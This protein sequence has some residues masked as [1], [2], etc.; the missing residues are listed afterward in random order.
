[1]FA[2][3][4]RLKEALS[5][6]V[7]AAALAACWSGKAS[8]SST[9]PTTG[10]LTVAIA[11]LTGTTGRVTV[12]GPGGYTRIL[13]ATST[14]A[15]LPTGRYTVVAAPATSGD[16]VVGTDTSRATVTGSPAT[17]AS[18]QTTSVTVTYGLSA[19]AGGL[20]IGNANAASSTALLE[21]D[22]AQLTASGTPAPLATIAGPS[23]AM[24]IAFDPRGNLW[25]VTPL[26]QNNQIVE[27]SAAQLTSAN[28]T[29]ILTLT[30]SGAYYVSA[31][32]FDSAGNL[33]M[34]DPWLC[35][36]YEYKAATLAGQSGAVTLAPDLAI[37][38]GGHA[39]PDHNP[40][41]IAFDTHGNLW[42]GDNGHIVS[43]NYLNDVYEYPADSLVP[44]F[45]GLNAARVITGLRNVGAVAFDAG[46][47]LWVTGADSSVVE[48]F[49]AAQLADTTTAPPPRVALALPAGTN[50][51]GLAFDNSG[52]LW[53]VDAALNTVYELST[54][55][56]AASGTISTPTVTL[57]AINGSL[58]EPWAIAFDPHASGLPLFDR[59][60]KVSQHRDG[61]NR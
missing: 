39:P 12:A 45:S 30:V 22:P 37:T 47:N 51:Q 57:G 44:G 19:F 26:L 13:T 55:Q 40:L 34:P 11:A 7:V 48:E 8:D 53:I 29:P 60:P 2:A 9:G 42:V 4:R 1:M 61:A 14:L 6:A 28:P 54:V 21:F 33:W 36:F 23:A 52:N 56:L 46:G 24:G 25:S 17:V 43:A 50:L 49:T 58:H 20:W 31:L 38:P 16:P 10:S 15:D 3:P 35:Y 32:A 18:N 5:G 27:Y 41:S 59:V